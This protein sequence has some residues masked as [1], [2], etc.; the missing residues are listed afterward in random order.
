MADV[1][2]EPSMEDI[3]SSIKKI[4]SDDSEKTLSVPRRPRVDL[5][6]IEVEP[7]ADPV[8]Q[9]HDDDD[10]FELNDAMLPVEA[11]MP[12]APIITAPIISPIAEAASRS[13]FDALQSVAPKSTAPAG[14]TTIDDL[15][16]ELLRPMLKEWLDAHLPGIVEGVVAKEVARISGRPL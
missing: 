8:T 16:R 7:K 11:E 9:A 10:V 3:L 14:G 6:T 15:A 4:I 5:R 1:G 2:H 12:D 13:A